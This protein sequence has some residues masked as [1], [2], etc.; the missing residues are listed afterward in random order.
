[1]RAPPGASRSCLPSGAV[2]LPD[3]AW[4]VLHELRLR[5]VMTVSPDQTV[6]VLIERGL[7]VQVV[8][9]VRITPAGRNVH[10]AWARVPAGSTV[11]AAVERAYQR[12]LPLNRALI[13]ACH[14]W[15]VLPSGAP[16]EHRDAR[17]DWG[18]VDRVRTINEQIGPVVRRVAA[19]VER[20]GAYRARLRA[21][22]ARLDEGEHEWLTSPRVDSYHTVWMQLHEDLLLALGADR[23]AEPPP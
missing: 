23:S 6:T 1:M 3:D 16:N 19:Q 20:F 8:R 2:V 15:Q 13:A 10:A 17:Y 5:G 7:A 21:A 11:E 9:G 14:D 4:T 22:L 18:V 12:F